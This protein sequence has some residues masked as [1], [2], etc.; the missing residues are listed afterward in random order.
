MCT[1]VYR[2]LSHFTSLAQTA[3]QFRHRTKT[4]ESVR[5]ATMLFFSSLRKYYLNKGRTVSQDLLE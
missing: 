4:Q 1:Y 3:H 2:L 5:M